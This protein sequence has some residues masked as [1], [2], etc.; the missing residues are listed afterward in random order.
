[1]NSQNGESIGFIDIFEVDKERELR[2]IKQMKLASD[3]IKG[4]K[5]YFSKFFDT[6]K[7]ESAERCF[8][9]L[10]RSS[11][12]ILTFSMDENTPSKV[13]R[14]AD[15]YHISEDK[16]ASMVSLDNGI[17]V[18]TKKGLIRVITTI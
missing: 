4:E 5:P 13:K 15:P 1:M 7:K 12:S 8:F 18:T 3:F 16:L 2:L 14:M 9:V 6:S 10:M 11:K 17:A